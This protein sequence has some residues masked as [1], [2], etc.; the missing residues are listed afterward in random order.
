MHDSLYAEAIP[1]LVQT[2]VLCSYNCIKAMTAHQMLGGIEAIDGVGVPHI[3][4]LWLRLAAQ[5][6]VSQTTSIEDG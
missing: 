2:I 1:F 3:K 6:G 5:N 4:M